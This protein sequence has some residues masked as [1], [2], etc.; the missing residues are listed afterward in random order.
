LP[1]P[2]NLGELKTAI[3]D[4]L[5]RTDQTQSIPTWIGLAEVDIRS[6]FRTSEMQTSAALTMTAGASTLALPADF[7]EAIRF[8]YVAGSADVREV[9]QAPFS[10]ITYAEESQTPGFPDEF[11]IIGD[12]FI[13]K[14]TPDAAYPTTLWYFLN[15][16]TLDQS[17]DAST[18]WLLTKYPNVYLYGSLLA[19]LPKVG[20]DV[21]AQIWSEYYNAGLDSIKSNDRSKRFAKAP[22]MR[23]AVYS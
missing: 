7:G 18:N 14:P 10:P 8:T 5:N 22:R 1:V 3:A 13:L 9:K 12:N 15:V 6:R 4:V 17:S 11:S 20:N 19:A 23:S 2:T 21:R 16:P